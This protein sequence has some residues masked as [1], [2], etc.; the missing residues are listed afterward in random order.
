MS[1]TVGYLDNKIYVVFLSLQIREG[2]PA[3]RQ[4]QEWQEED[5]SEEAHPQPSLW[6]GAQGKDATETCLKF[7]IASLYCH[8]YIW[9]FFH[10]SYTLLLS[11]TV[12]HDHERAGDTSTVGVGVAQRH[13]WPQRLPGRGDGNTGWDC[14]WWRHTQGI[15]SPRPSKS[16]VVT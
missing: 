6:G 11:H 14:L 13:V 15:P 7:I 5:Q 12:Q 2:V 9:S 3:A 8:S 10:L 1:S 16:C 4:V